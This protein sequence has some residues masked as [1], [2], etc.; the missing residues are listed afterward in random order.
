MHWGYW[1]PV[2]LLSTD[3]LCTPIADMTWTAPGME[4]YGLPNIDSE[5]LTSMA[6]ANPVPTLGEDMG[7]VAGD[8]WF[9]QGGSV[10][11]HGWR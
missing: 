6:V 4:A 3:N 11:I 5:P 8:V 10:R 9:V 7:F 1:G 2:G